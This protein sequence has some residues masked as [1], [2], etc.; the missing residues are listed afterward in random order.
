MNNMM[1]ELPVD[2]IGH[3]CIYL[4]YSDIANFEYTSKR[5]LNLIQESGVWRRTASQTEFPLVNGML[6]HIKGNDRNVVKRFKILIS[7]DERLE[8]M[9]NALIVKLDQLYASTITIESL[10]MRKEIKRK[11]Y[12][13]SCFVDYEDKEDGEESEV[14]ESDLLNKM[15]LCFKNETDDP[16]FTCEAL[17]FKDMLY[18]YVD[19]D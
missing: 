3:I 4:S 13:F 8:K 7:M 19:M 11:C 16:D 15:R 9:S 6:K 18:D 2:A 5:M 17:M 10:L 12:R 14:S 1:E